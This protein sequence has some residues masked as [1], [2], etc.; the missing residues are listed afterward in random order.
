MLR[1]STDDEVG[2]ETATSSSIARQLQ[3][4]EHIPT[5]TT[6]TGMMVM[7]C[8]G[9]RYFVTEDKMVGLAPKDAQ[10]G[11][12]VYILASARVPFVIRPLD[13][14]SLPG[15]ALPEMLDGDLPVC[16]MLGEA[17]VHGVMKGEMIGRPGFAWK[18]IAIL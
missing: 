13:R 9:C 6:A 17:Y 7:T 12:N 5:E 11:D 8:E 10:I 4:I 3:I 2:T 15:G 16:T 18:R 1:R 14:E